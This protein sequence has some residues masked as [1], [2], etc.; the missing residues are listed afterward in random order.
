MWTD[1]Y[2]PNSKALRSQLR[3]AFA[4]LRKKGY[5]AR[6][7][8]WCCQSCAWSAIPEDKADKVVF[9]HNQD[10]KDML[11]G[12]GTF[13]SVYLAWCGNADEIREAFE[14]RGFEIDHDGSEDSRIIVK[15]PTIGSV[16]E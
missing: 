6:M 7:N 15:R 5:F 1:S 9:Y 13:H 11:D 16:E 10:A 3:Y 2:I 12:W 8:F 4:D 14:S